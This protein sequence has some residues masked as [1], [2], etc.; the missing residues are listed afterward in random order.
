[1]G[2]ISDSFLAQAHTEINERLETTG[3]A[4]LHFNFEVSELTASAM[5]AFLV[6][7]EKQPNG[8]DICKVPAGKYMRIA[9]IEETAKS[10]GVQP[11]NGGRPPIEWISELLAPQFGYRQVFNLPFM[12]YY[13]FLNGSTS[14]INAF[15]YVPVEKRIV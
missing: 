12:E 10:L 5:F 7:T 14:V 4:L 6:N 8:F 15:L 11:W 1:M 13:G 3:N 2:G 9:L